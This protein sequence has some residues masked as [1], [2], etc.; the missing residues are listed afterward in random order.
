M[1]EMCRYPVAHRWRWINPDAIK[2]RLPAQHRAVTVGPGEAIRTA[3][4]G[5]EA[6]ETSAPRWSR[7][8]ISSSRVVGHRSCV[9][10][11]TERVGHRVPA[12]HEV[13]DGRMLQ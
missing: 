2:R 3:L 1:V 9:A 7:P 5:A 13:E 8:V 10:G 11:G 4:S 6:L 12:E